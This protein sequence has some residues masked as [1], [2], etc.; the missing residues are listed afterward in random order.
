ME[1]TLENAFEIQ[2]KYFYQGHTL[3]YEFRAEALHKLMKVIQKYENEIMEAL[4][5]DLGKS[6][7]EAYTNEIGILY[8]E[9]KHSLKNLKKWMKS[10]DITLEIFLQP[11][12]GKIYSEPYGNTLIIAP[13]NYPFQLLIAPLIAAIAAGNTAILKPSELSPATEK[14]AEKIIREIFDERFIKVIKGGV[15]ETTELLK[16]PFDKIFF[17]GSVPVGKIVMKAAAKHLTPITLELGGKSPTIVHKDANLK[18]AA[19]KIVWGKFNN[20]GQTCVAPD[21]LLVHKDVEKE[22]IENIKKTI[23]DFYGENPKTSEDYGRIINRR[24]TERLEKLI[25]PKKVIIGGQVN[26]EEKYIAPTIM[27]GV[28]LE[29][30][31]M[32]DEIF[33]P[34]LPVMTYEHLEEV[35]KI[36]RGFSK[37]LALYLFT[38]S[39]QVEKHIMEKV[40]FGGGG[41]NTTILHVASGQLPFGGVGQ[42]GMGSYHGKAGFLEFSHKKSVLKQP[43]NFDFGITYPGKK[44]SLKWIKKIM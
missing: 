28:T 29:D 14:I 43:S 42:S 7:F 11:G 32:E 8:L 22:L 39:S 13:W 2:K 20:A 21:Y 10:R 37:P 34:I 41:I 31:I 9:I 4:K 38:N 1:K 40:T 3:P 17:T 19:N 6:E 24:H 23:K 5:N 15:D 25:D 30:K 12:K 33:G 35:I 26:F 36:I 16:L 27:A 18:F 44:I